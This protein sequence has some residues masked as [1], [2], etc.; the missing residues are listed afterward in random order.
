VRRLLPDLF[1]VALPD[2]WAQCL[3][4]G[5]YTRSTRGL[6]LA[7]VGF[8]HAAFAWQLT[9]VLARYYD[10]LDGRLVL[11]RV[12]PALLG[13]PVR[14]ESPPGRDEGYPHVCGPL[15]VAAVVEQVEIRRWDGRW[16]LPAWLEE[17]APLARVGRLPHEEDC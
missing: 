11:L 9:G 7:E 16:Q 4:S 2:E 14:V 5:C 12:D 10:D 6:G 1:H 13:V 17:H 8:L 3:P 15:P